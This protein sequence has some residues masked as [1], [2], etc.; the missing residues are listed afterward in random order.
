MSGIDSLSS[1]PRYRTLVL[2]PFDVER[3]AVSLEAS[4]W[5][6]RVQTLFK[7]L[8]TVPGRQRRRDDLIE[9]LW[10]EA[11]PDSAA[12]NLRIL[13]HRLRLTLGGPSPVLSTNGWVSLNPAYRW[14]LDLEEMEALVRGAHG[15][16]NRLE[17][18]IAMVRGEPFVE[19]RY[20]DWA[21]GLTTRAVR[22][23]RDACLQ[24]ATICTLR[25]R[26][27]EAALWYERLLD[28]DPL[29]EDAL[30]GVM[31]VTARAGRLSDA[32]RRYEAFRTKLADELDTEP[33]TET[34]N[35]VDRIRT[36]VDI[37]EG[38][39]PLPSGG[40]LGAAPSEPLIGRSD[41]LER[42]VLALDAVQG[43]HG[44]LVVI[45]G[46][47]GVG[48]T[49]LA[50]EVMLRLRGLGFLVAVARCAER[51]RAVPFAAF[52]ELLAQTHGAVSPTLRQD[53]AREFPHLTLLLPHGSAPGPDRAMEDA[54]EQR[55]LFRDCAGFLDRASRERP[56]GLLLDDLHW[57][58]EGSLAL[59]TYLAREMRAHPVLLFA[60]YRDG[61]ISRDHPLARSMR[62]MVREGVVERLTLTRLGPQETFALV[63]SLVPDGQTLSEFSEYVYHR[64]RGNPLF[65]RKVVHALGGRYRLVRQIGAGGMGRVFEAVDDRTGE[66][67]AVKL[68]FAR[69]EVDPKA[70]LRFQQEGSVL[71]SLRH[72]NIVEVR[73]TFVEEYVSCIV[74]ELLRGRPLAELLA[75]GSLPLVRVKNLALQVL[76]GLAGAHERGVVHRDVKP[77]NV[78]VLEDDHVKVTDFGIARLV[79]SPTDTSLTSTGMT[80]GTPL[81]MAPEQV[82]GGSIDAR[83]DLYAVGAMM[84]QMVTGRVPFEAD[85]P[86]AVAFMQVNDTPAPTRAYRPG[87]PDEWDALILRAL[88]KA[89]ADRFQSAVAMEKVLAALS[90]VE[91]ELPSRA[92]VSGGAA[93]SPSV[94]A[95][96]RPAHRRRFSTGVLGLSALAAGGV[97]LLGAHLLPHRTTASALF[98]GPAAIAVDARNDVY[99]SD[100]GSNRIVELNPSGA[101][102]HAWGSTGSGPLQFNSP[103]SLALASDGTLDVVDAM[104][105][106]IEVLRQGR[107]VDEAQWDAGSLALDRS[108]H[109]FASDFG[110]NR[111][112]EFGSDWL[113]VRTIAIP[114]I[115]VGAEPFPAA[116][117]TDGQG[118]L[119]VADRDNNRVVKLSPTGKLLAAFGRFGGRPRSAAAPPQ[120]NKPSGVGVDGEGRIY[121][122]DT[123]NNRIQ[124]LSP[125]GRVLKILS[126]SAR[127]GNRG[128]QPVSLAV[129]RQGNIYVADYYDNQVAKMSPSG[130][131]IWAT[132][133]S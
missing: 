78:M 113:L 71:A 44:R 46:E 15:D 47:A 61:D 89:P 116:L 48:K 81:Y 68:M 88:A 82:Q 42:V 12:G 85:N 23:W 129:D 123:R 84:Y 95:T 121:V 104:N 20:D 55:T 91:V 4:H 97:L 59:L 98:H 94:V 101:L 114:E 128:G 49:R 22:V 96:S 67:A 105:R 118:N 38:E 87:V 41:E 37:H 100:Q 65:V 106:R 62:D 86:L 110:N 133:D 120:F 99:V 1:N 79:R 50:Q 57:A 18:A 27:D 75:D 132:P 72:P 73:G 36:Q 33:A 53:V 52:L 66:C 3:D 119:Y 34:E 115:A 21:V 112:W 32:L 5:Q 7:L 90:T 2:G 25:G 80:L 117:A 125:S 29:D 102:L 109:L 13:V 107:Q 9:L 56:L 43:G 60:A 10:P 35:L 103:G 16:A 39:A 76:A 26:H 126:A 51:D 19:D 14:D 64:T 92:W 28:A 111:I 54:D 131:V 74:M 63:G 108:G 40:F 124:I 127:P 130:R 8:A 58:D 30:R 93:G 11:D 122:A 24:L 17:T 69:A 31:T 83:A 77:A 6:P 45:S 70:I